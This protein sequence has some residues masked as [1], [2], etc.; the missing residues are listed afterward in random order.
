MT[1]SI[2]L[3]LAACALLANLKNTCAFLH[4]HPSSP[5]LLISGKC[6]ASSEGLCMTSPVT[7]RDAVL[8]GLSGFGTLSVMGG[9]PIA[10]AER[11]PSAF[12]TAY[13]RYVGRIERGLKYFEGPLQ[14]A[15]KDGKWDEVRDAIAP[16]GEID[17]LFAPLG[18]FA[19]TYSDSVINEET[20]DM[21]NDIRLFK[22]CMEKLDEAAQKKDLEG[23]VLAY[24]RGRT[25]LGMYV[26][27]A[28]K[29]MP[30]SLDKIE[31]S[32]Q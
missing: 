25:A 27:V 23:A 19:T 24:K 5:S 28:N 20:T 3:V 12:N 32:M 14:T 8:R 15:V 29:G 30:R 1:K 7:R 10:L 13:G 17:R 9:V 4:T 26:D 31:P 2:A 16:K 11:S 6:R 18:I 22:V 21:R